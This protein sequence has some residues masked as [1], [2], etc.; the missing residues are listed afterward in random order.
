MPILNYHVVTTGLAGVNPNIV[1]ID[2]NDTDATVTTVGYLNALVDGLDVPLS[3]NMIALV[4]TKT[5]PNALPTSV[6]FYD[7]SFSAGKWSL[8][9]SSSAGTVNAGGV[10]ELAYYASAGTAVS[11]LTTG[12]NGVLITSGTGVPSISSTLP[13]AVQ[14]NITRLGTIAS[15]GAPLG[16]AFGGTGVANNAANTL[17]WSGAYAATFTLTG[18]T[19]VTFPTSG[20]L[21]TTA[22]GGFTWNEE[23]G[24]SAAMAVNNAYIANNAGLVTLTLPAT[25]A[26]GEQVKVVGKG[27]GGWQIA[28]NAG[29]T[30]N[31]GANAST[32]GV[33]GYIASS[34]QSDSITLVCITANTDWINVDAPQ[35]N[36][37]YA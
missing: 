17:T 26:V 21:A 36:I 16:A 19:N 20:T 28:Q 7:I 3:E 30:I 29:Q 9:S 13:T 6:K 31:V 14:D 37:T 4:S 32:T 5:S 8:S 12:N 22:G 1:Y 23:T 10:S 24:T 11:G 27:A 15:I 33:G 25:A 35:G 2:T 34:A 18:V